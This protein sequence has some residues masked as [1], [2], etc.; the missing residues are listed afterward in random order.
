MRGGLTGR[1]L[2]ASALFALLIGA[3]FAVLPS[4]VADLR[5]LERRARQSE[6]VLQVCVSGCAASTRRPYPRAASA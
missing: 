2:I 6:E 3:A 4:S 1:M 5:V